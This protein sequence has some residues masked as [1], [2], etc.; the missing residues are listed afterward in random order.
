MTEDDSYVELHANSAFSFL[1]GASQPESF[2][3]RAA[4]LGMSSIALADR[5]G[6]YGAARFHTAAKRCGVQAHIGAEVAVSAL[7]NRLFPP[8]WLPHAEREDPARLTLL[9]TSQV[10]YQNLCQLITRLK[11]R[12]STKSEGAATL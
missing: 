11:M 8:A 3:T 6:V 9:C 2:I 7:G 5:N 1:A 12:E 4:E 10:G